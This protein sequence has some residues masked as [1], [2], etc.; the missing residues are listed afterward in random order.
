MDKQT[1]KNEILRKV[2]EILKEISGD[3]IFSKFDKAESLEKIKNA[4]FHDLGLDSMMVFEVI[5]QL[6]IEFNIATIN[7]QEMQA[8]AGVSDAVDFVYNVKY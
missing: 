3:E 5:M 8:M 2:I 4:N 7:S 6:Q 1:V